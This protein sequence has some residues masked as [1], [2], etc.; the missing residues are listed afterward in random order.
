M[1]TLCRFSL[2]PECVCKFNHVAFAWMSLPLFKCVSHLHHH[3][4]CLTRTCIDHASTDWMHL[5]VEQQRW[6]LQ[7]FILDA[8]KCTCHRLVLMTLLSLRG[9]N[10]PIIFGCVQNAFSYWTNTPHK[11]FFYIQ[12]HS[13]IQ[14]TTAD[15]EGKRVYCFVLLYVSW[16]WKRWKWR[17]EGK[18]VHNIPEHNH[19]LSHF[20]RVFSI[21]NAFDTINV[22]TF[23]LDC[24]LLY[25]LFVSWPQY[26]KDWL[27][28]DN[29]HVLNE[30]EL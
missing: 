6:L 15:D 21:E 11:F 4:Q 7:L 8:W 23:F 19:W 9:S 18:W 28:A 14:Y 3:L 12:T 29:E 16:R 24:R 30:F 25:Y 13:Y 22:L 26:N 27:Y 2:F 5:V 17:D 10:F 20:L 1:S